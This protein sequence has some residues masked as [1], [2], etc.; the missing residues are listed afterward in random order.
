MGVKVR[1]KPKGS[2]MFW[3]FVNHAGKRASKKVGTERELAE[4]AAGIIQQKLALGEIDVDEIA[5]KPK[6]VLPSFRQYAERFYSLPSDRRKEATATEYL[7]TLRRHAFPE[8]GNM[9]LDRI[10]R[11]DLVTLSET[12][13]LK[14]LASRTVKDT[15]LAPIKNVF[16]HAVQS[17][18]I[19]VNPMTG[20][21]FEARSDFQ[22]DPYTEDEAETLLA[23]MKE[24][25]KVSK[26]HYYPP[27]LLALRT[28]LRIG[29]IEALE[30]SDVDFKERLIS[31]T[32]SH[33]RG[34]VGSTKSKRSRKVD[35]SPMLVETLR[36]LKRK[37]WVKWGAIGVPPFVFAGVKGARLDR[38]EMRK[39]MHRVSDALG[40]TRKRLH[41]LRHTYR[42]G[43]YGVTTSLM[44]RTN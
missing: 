15:V 10:R 8:M 27:T 31:V 11:S 23:G 41:D 43:S 22:V 21:K 38:Y 42:S 30:W 39:V 5:A 40:L 37:V 4:K 7:K 34:V 25:G 44:C 19:A 33:R 9:T 29:E 1:E 3:I 16:N 24:R 17:E 18:L 14:G 32:K 28:G 13:L 36:E 35:M 12:L 20:F 26:G 6:R 2:G